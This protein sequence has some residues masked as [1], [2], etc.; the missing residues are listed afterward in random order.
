[1]D[2]NLDKHRS[3]SL[4]V[5]FLLI[6][7]FLIMFQGFQGKKAYSLLRSTITLFS[8]IHKISVSM[9]RSAKLIWSDYIAL[10]GVRQENKELKRQIELLKNLNNQYIEAVEANKR[11]R[12]L[13]D[14]REQIEEPT[15]SAQIIGKDSTNW[16]KSVLLDKG[17]MDGVAVNMPVVTYNGVVGK[18]QEVTNHT[19]K[20]LLIND[21]H[22]SVAVLIQRSR[23]EGIAAGSGKDYCIIKY[24]GKD[25]DIRIGDR[26]ITSGI[27]GVFPKGLVVGVVSKIQKNNYDLFQY[28]EVVPEA[29]ISNLEEVFIIKRTPKF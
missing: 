28:V 20:V 18:I 26:V 11:L 1:M 22:S 8:S 29:K 13:L 6:S 23:A 15:F 10:V 5:F 19:A 25:F 17:S 21:I 27:G 24:A 3:F 7:I 9:V 4:L 14:F 16:C 2:L 12:K